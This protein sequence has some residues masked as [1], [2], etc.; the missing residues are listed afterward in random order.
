MKKALAFILIISVSFSIFATTTW[1]GQGNSWLKSEIS[2]V[3]DYGTF[4]STK[5]VLSTRTT[6]SSTWLVLNLN[7]LTELKFTEW[8][9]SGEFKVTMYPNYVRIA[10]EDGKISKEYKIDSDY[11]FNGS[12]YLMTRNSKMVVELF[13]GLCSGN[14]MVVE[15]IS[16]VGE[17]RKY[18]IDKNGVF[19]YFFD[20]LDECY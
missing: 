15:L 17:S 6:N 12:G 8:D 16:G 2:G 14:N 7:G 1:S 5:H 10:S 4:D 20:W 18:T 13:R 11:S 19:D 9:K 3:S